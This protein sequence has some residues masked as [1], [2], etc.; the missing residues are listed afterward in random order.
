MTEMNFEWIIM[1]WT[2][3]W[4]SISLT[5]VANGSL[6]RKD[7]FI[8]VIYSP[9]L[10]AYW[11]EDESHELTDEAVELNRSYYPFQGSVE[12]IWILFCEDNIFKYLN[13]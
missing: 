12:K 7:D 10:L 5:T 8:I 3:D 2:T 1:N 6:F 9:S 11:A 13:F 4:E